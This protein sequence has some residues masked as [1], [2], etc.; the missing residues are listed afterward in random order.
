MS[1]WSLEY[2]IDVDDANHIVYEK[3][4]GV[5]RVSTAKDFVSDYEEEV[6]ELIQK[7]WARFCDLSNWKTATPEVIDIIGAHL[8]W[9]RKNNLIWSVNIINNPVTYGQ[10]QRMFEKG[11]TKEISRTFRTR[12]EG[13]RFLTDQGFRVKKTTN[14][15]QV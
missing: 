1:G 10:L 14:G 4:F 8:V 11:G 3:V 2:N 12:Q 13:E 9:C 15:Y 5:W 7:P 6:A